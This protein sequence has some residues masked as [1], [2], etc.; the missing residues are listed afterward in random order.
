MSDPTR[1]TFLASAA[2]A[3]YFANPAR[4]VDGTKVRVAVMGTGG[5]GTELGRLYAALP[6]VQ[7]ATV[8]DVDEK[9]VAAAATAIEAVAKKSDNPAPTPVGDFRKILDDKEVDGMIV[10]TCNHWHAPAAILACAAGKHVY[11][12][13]PCSHNPWEGEQMVAAARKHNRAVQMGVQR[14]STP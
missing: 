8:C 4:A 10:A 13:K 5:R 6:G 9:R 11:V 14:R 7:V 12:E 1:R 2:L 3:A